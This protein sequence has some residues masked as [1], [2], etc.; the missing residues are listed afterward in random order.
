M[1][2]IFDSSTRTNT[3]RFKMV[4]EAEEYMSLNLLNESFFTFTFNLGRCTGTTSGIVDFIKDNPKLNFLIYPKFNRKY[5]QDIVSLDNVF[6][7]TSFNYMEDIDCVIVD[8]YTLN[9]NDSEY[10]NFERFVLN[11]MNSNFQRFNSQPT[12]FLRL[13]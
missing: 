6:L 2:H 12:I 9:R 7:N 11:N 3:K 8:D 5:L 4:K 1:E 13:S 10:I